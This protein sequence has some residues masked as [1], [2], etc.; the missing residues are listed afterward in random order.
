MVIVTGRRTA[1]A[2][3]WL[4]LLALLPISLLVGHEAV[5]GAQYG[6]GDAFAGAMTAGGHD[7]YWTAFSLVIAALT[8]TFV[9]R[10]GL[11]AARLRWRLHQAGAGGR[12]D[13]THARD[14]VR[15]PLPGRSWSRELRSIW[16]GL[17]VT[18]AFAFAVQE[19]LEH[20][21]SGETPHGLASLIGPEHPL[22]I[23]ILALVT[24]VVAAAGAIIRWRVRILELRVAHAARTSPRRRH[25][26]ATAPAREWPVRGSLRA[27]AWFL[28]RLLAGRA[29]PLP[30]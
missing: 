7:G 6:L 19:N 28:V 13:G 14:D 21:L 30:A 11:R 22:A 18:T 23:P 29:P 17:F 24:A 15:A 16:P 2:L 5:F 12:R 26:R 10:E 20:I 25:P 1:R 9:A 4:R 8:T 27:H 3:P